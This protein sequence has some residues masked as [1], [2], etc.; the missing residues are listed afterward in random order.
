MAAV[1]A[2]SA[3]R[4]LYRAPF[5][6]FVAT[7][8]RLAAALK[9][10][11][12][13]AGAAALGKRKRPSVSAWTVNQLWWSAREELDAL[14]ASAA[15]LRAGE[16]AANGAHRD[17]LARLRAKAQAILAGDGHAANEA[18]LRRVAQTLSAIAASG[19]FEPDEPGMIAVDRDPPG[20]EAL[21]GIEL[22]APDPTP[23]PT[24]APAAPKESANARAERERAE[25]ERVARERR[26]QLAQLERE[27]AD[28]RRRVAGADA[29]VEQARS[30]LAAA[31]AE[32]AKSRATEAALQAKLARDGSD[33]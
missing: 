19:G 9:A 31:E 22:I 20:F 33:T 24:P 2:A 28:A 23:A 14:L 15:R 6:A 18:T 11:G 25:R 27:L 30:A 13:K 7:R 29:W 21:A 3:L 10:A 8:D 1:T 12:D 16:L 5:D 26:E 17:A 4:E 32:L